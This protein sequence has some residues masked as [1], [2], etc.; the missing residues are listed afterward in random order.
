MNFQILGCAELRNL[1]I[2]LLNDSKNFL[3]LGPSD[4]QVFQEIFVKF[5]KKI[6]QT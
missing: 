5:S 4:L 6:F 3:V 1:F 2:N